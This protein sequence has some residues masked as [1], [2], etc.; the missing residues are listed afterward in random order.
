MEKKLHEKA[1]NANSVL[2]MLRESAPLLE[3]HYC[4]AETAQM[5]KTFSCPSGS[6]KTLQQR[7]HSISTVY[8]NYSES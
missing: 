7:Q 1:A 8:E 5:S 4:C 6:N 3:K 2:H